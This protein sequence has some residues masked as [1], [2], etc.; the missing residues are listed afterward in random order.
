MW[1][2]DSQDPKVHKFQVLPAHQTTCNVHIRDSSIIHLKLFLEAEAVVFVESVVVGF[3]EAEAFG[4]SQDGHA[5]MAIGKGVE[6]EAGTE[7]AHQ[8]AP[9]DP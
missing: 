7:G 2:L 6:S 3:G 9:W 4:E 5:G 8:P 1:I